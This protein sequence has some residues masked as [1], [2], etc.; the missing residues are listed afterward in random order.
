[1]LV[2]FKLDPSGAPSPAGEQG[3]GLSFAVLLRRPIPRCEVHPRPLLATQSEMFELA[4]IL[5]VVSW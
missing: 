2:S 3:F 5:D 4:T 1:M